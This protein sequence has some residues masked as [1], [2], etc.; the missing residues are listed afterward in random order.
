MRLWFVLQKY[1]NYQKKRRL[2]SNYS[3]K[4]KSIFRLLLHFHEDSY[5]KNNLR[6]TSLQYQSFVSL[7]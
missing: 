1:V 4:G 6:P 2:S 5:L 7:K 3:Y